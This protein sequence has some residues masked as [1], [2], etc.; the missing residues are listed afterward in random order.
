MVDKDGRFTYSKIIAGNKEK[1]S[2][3]S[4]QL[5]GKVLTVNALKAESTL[6]VLNFSGKLIK[7]LRLKKGTQLISL[8]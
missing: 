4:I 5:Q 7:E 3:I 2:V 8:E 6:R 1:T